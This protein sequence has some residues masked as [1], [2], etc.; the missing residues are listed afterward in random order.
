MNLLLYT[1]DS[2]WSTCPTFFSRKENTV[3]IWEYAVVNIG[4]DLRNASGELPINFIREELDKYGQE[5]WEVISAVPKE[6]NTGFVMF[7]KREVALHVQDRPESYP[8]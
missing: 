8:E 5:G 6:K 3:Q 4:T 7:M 1:T 2:S